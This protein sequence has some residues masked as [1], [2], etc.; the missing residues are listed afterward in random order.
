MG[1]KQVTSMRWTTRAAVV[2]AGT[3][4]GVVL[5]RA[6]AARGVLPSGLRGDG[7]QGE[8]LV[9]TINRP[10]WEVAPD[11]QPPEPL[12][13]LGEAVEVRV[14]PAPGDRGSE[15]AIRPTG[16]DRDARRAARLALRQS[17]QLLE[18]G[19]VLAPDAP[20]TARRTLLNR[21]LEFATRHAREEGRL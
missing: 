21:P 16:T 6:L 17:K 11:G 20:P 18:T 13:R 3:A 19:E 8:W 4:G 14:R 5:R 7:P 10:P 12:A 15:L 9:L 1:R 2:V